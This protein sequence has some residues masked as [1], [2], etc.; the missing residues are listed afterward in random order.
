MNLFFE[1]RRMLMYIQMHIKYSLQSVYK[2]RKRDIKK[3]FF[4]FFTLRYF[5]RQNV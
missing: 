1:V 4:I 3:H 2:L 5:P